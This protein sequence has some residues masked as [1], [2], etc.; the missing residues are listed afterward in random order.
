MFKGLGNTYEK[1]QSADT[2]N[3]LAAMSASLGN[4][5]G[6]VP[7]L[8]GP[9]LHCDGP[10]PALEGPAGDVLYGATLAA[11]MEARMAVNVYWVEAISNASNNVQDALTQLTA[12]ITPSWKTNLQPSATWQNLIDS[13]GERLSTID[14]VAI[15]KSHSHVRKARDPGYQPSAEAGSTCHN[16]C[17]NSV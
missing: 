12:S 16:P 10:L 6:L 8:A 7:A 5:G 4:L 14:T 17:C 9:V 13:C 1:R 3:Y 2:G 15:V 11:I